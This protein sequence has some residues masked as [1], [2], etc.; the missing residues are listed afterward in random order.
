[1]N[2]FF[3]LA[4]A[5]AA[6]VLLGAFFFGGLWWTVRRGV[7]SE[8]P[9]LWFFGSLLLRM[10]ITLTG[11]YFVGQQYWERWLL[12]LLGFV[13]ARLL[14]GWLT[15]PSAADQPRPAQGASYAP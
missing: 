6:G 13:L 3:P 7:S 5:A 11:F 14:V 12:C 9:A 8:R 15:R 10:S 4:I 1:M 2:E